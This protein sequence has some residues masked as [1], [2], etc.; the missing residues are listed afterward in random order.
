MIL[1]LMLGANDDDAND[2]TELKS[3]MDVLQDGLD[4]NVD[5]L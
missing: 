2:D 5:G 3:I 4:E 1:L